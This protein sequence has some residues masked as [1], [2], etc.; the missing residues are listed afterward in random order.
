MTQAEALTILKTGTNV[1]L[2]GEPGSGKTHTINAY[3]NWLR[4]AGV[5]PAITAATGIA[6]T[7]VSGMTIHSWSGIGILERVSATDA[8]RIAGKE[9][10][11][12]RV[13]KAH[14]LIIDEISMLSA[15]T[16][17][18]VDTICKEIR[19]NHEAFGGLQV[20][21]VGDFFQ[22]PPVNKKGG[23]HNFCYD[24]MAWRD[25]KP[26]ICYITEQHRQEDADYLEVLTAIRR[27]DVEE[28]HYERIQT[29]HTKRDVDL[30]GIPKLYSHNADVDRINAD[31][32]AKL[33]GRAKQYRMRSSGSD[34]L[35][36]G[37]KRGCLSPETLE[38]K[39]GAAVMF[40]K[41]SSTGRYVNGTLGC[42]SMFESSGMPVI[43]TRS[44]DYITAESVDWQVEEN[45]KIRAS[46]TQLPLRLAYAMTVHKS[47][48][49]SLDAAAIDLSQAF[50]Y[51]QGYVALS[52]VR[53][54]AG[55]YL[56]GIN[57][58]ALLVHPEI[59]EKDRD[60]RESSNAA[61]AAFADMPHKEVE[62]MHKR[63]IKAVGGAWS[64]PAIAKRTL[65]PTKGK[66][67]G[68]VPR[69][70]ETL[71][72]VRDANSLESAAK[73]RG[74]TEST[75]VKHL[76]ELSAAGKLAPEDFSHILLDEGA[77]R[78]IQKALAA[79]GEERLSPVFKTLQGRYTF[80]DIRLTRLLSK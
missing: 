11:A 70:A 37:L 13:A 21:L 59:L 41:N 78:E 6:A 40:T 14:V 12:R 10:V 74:L 77:V 60:F 61:E 75:I 28:M 20:I 62:D 19:R 57:E 66:Q 67:R 7:H 71:Q 69:L 49:Q 53:T 15:A 58:R 23:E 27:G 52:R 33:P 31:E 79:K 34:V 1:F 4:S 56:L 8:D 42:V 32:L 43:E 17:D 55:L 51:G 2:T 25:L 44:G 18:G 50:E 36:E 5:E 48:G 72:V 73:A 80:D 65:S 68:L 29:R 76:E 9:H 35:V 30:P 47:Q 16:L 24:S 38:L 54:L 22:L 64:A 39:E 46:I 3:V 63:F 45:G 26:L